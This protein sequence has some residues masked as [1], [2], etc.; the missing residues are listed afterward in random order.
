MKL[1]NVSVAALVL[2]GL[3]IGAQVNSPSSLAQEKTAETK[4]EAKVAKKAEGRVP[5]YYGQVGISDEQKKKI[6]TIQGGYEDKIAALRKE[7]AALE[8]KRDDEVKGVLTAD[9]QK[10]LA[11][12]QEAGKKKAAETRTKKKPEASEKSSSSDAKS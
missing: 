10:K 9:Q 8:E 1:R 6:Y 5:Q 3:M 7:I 2:A 12:L 4:A 11:E